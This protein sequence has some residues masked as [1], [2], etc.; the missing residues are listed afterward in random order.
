M[1][2]P[3]C[4]APRGLLPWQLR[5][6]TTLLCEHLDEG[7]SVTQLA[8]ACGLSRSDFS[9]KF[10]ASSGRSPH[11]WLRHARVEKAKQ[12][13]EDPR[14]PLAQISMECG[15]FDQAHFCR[16]FSRFEGV[17]PKGWRQRS[18]ALS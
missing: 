17:S 2:Q 1:S 7:I 8:V 10:K 5:R 3:P 18:A 9:R 12:L 13:L 4:S 14:Q 16:I 11:Q 15:F 6:A